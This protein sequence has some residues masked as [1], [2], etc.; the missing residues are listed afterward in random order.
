[1]TH[2]RV[3]A[4][5]AGAAVAAL[6]SLPMPVAGG[7]LWREGVWLADGVALACFLA[8]SLGLAVPLLLAARSALREAAAYER[9]S[10]T[11]EGRD[12]AGPPLDRHAGRRAT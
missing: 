11:S 4:L 10:G 7:W 6:L 3:L 2:H 12:L 1:M 5:R 9:A 8:V